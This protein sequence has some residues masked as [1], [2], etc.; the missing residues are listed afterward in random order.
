M[1]STSFKTAVIATI[2]ALIPPTAVFGQSADRPLTNADVINMVKSKL[3]ES[4]VVGA[5]Q[6]HPGK[7]DTSTNGLIAL[8]TAGVTEIELNA[9]MAAS[10]KGAANG[11]MLGAGAPHPADASATSPS[12]GVNTTATSANS[13][14]PKA[15]VMQGNSSRELP[16]E[17][18][19]LAQT[20][21]KPSSMK[22]LAA[23]S[24]MTQGMQSGINTATYGATSHMNSGI[25][26]ASVQSAGSILSGVMSHRTPTVTYVWGVP[27]PAST[28][29]L[30][31]SSPTFTV[32]FS[33]APGVNPDDYAP[34]IV[35][36]TPAQNT[37]RIIGATQGKEDVRSSPAADWEMYSHFLEEP[38]A[39]R[40]EKV[41]TG[42]YKIAPASELLPGE[43]GLVLRPI[44][45]AKK[46]SGGDVAR[47]QGDGL[48]FNAV[49]TFKISNSAE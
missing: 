25:G 43:Y 29:V 8:H 7:F 9:I 46:F 28:N 34:A 15:Q 41:G 14:M 20:K 42:K 19:Q 33:R 17:K 40:P 10:G 24:A 30:Q 37:C 13:C 22:N 18:T 1:N 49:W 38:V 48:M 44:S 39:I 3:P 45:R 2:L 35:K 4:V 16:L 31:T 11:G 26:G 6:S 23:D 32:D 27:S 36:L 47:S 5:V 21:T 12:S